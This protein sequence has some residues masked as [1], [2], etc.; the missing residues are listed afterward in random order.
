MIKIK[1]HDKT[2]WNQPDCTICGK[3]VSTKYFIGMTGPVCDKCEAKTHQDEADKRSKSEKEL[4][5]IIARLRGLCY[6]GILTVGAENLARVEREQEIDE[7][8]RLLK[9]KKYGAGLK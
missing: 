8:F 5:K 7:V 1:I 3:L 9:K 2:K 6:N 4:I